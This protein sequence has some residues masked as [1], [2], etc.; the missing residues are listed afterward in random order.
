VE[1]VS[2]ARSVRE[3]WEVPRDLLLGRYPPFV[4]GGPLPRGDVPVFVLHGAEPRSLE[5]QL[6]HLD[7]NGYA[8]LTADEYLAV[9]RREQPPPE[10]AVLLTFDDGRG[11][12]WGVAAPLLERFGMRAVVFLV[13]GR[14]RSRPGPLPPTWA[15]VE[16]G[17][18]DASE[19]LDREAGEG[20]LLCWE[21]VASLS[22]RGVFD[23]QSHSLTHARIHTGGRL[24]GFATPWSRRGYDAFDQ[25]LVR[26]GDRDLLGENVP[27]GTPL[28]QSAP[29]T[30]EALRFF[31][32][33][34]VRAAC[35]ALVEAEGE[36]F[37]RRADWE[38]VLGR[39][40]P[41]APVPG[42]HETRDEQVAAIERELAESRRLLEERVGRPV[43]HLCYPWHTF[44]PTAARLSASTGYQAVFCGKVPGVPIT[45]PGGD[46]QRIA[47]LGEDYLRLLPGQGRSTLRQVL[48]EKW[49]RRFGAGGAGQ[50]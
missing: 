12:L 19:V 47:R 26:E 36:G 21:E 43:L 16:A 35:V 1:R 9:M 18:V 31:E 5:G 37:F 40:V 39:L 34:A 27:L 44:G 7:T 4:T 28:F 13:P 45:R 46:L 29:R 22:Q 38:S 3:A 42:R 17:R 11:S 2:L 6:R 50:A 32:D 41:R 33:P 24:A 10:R 15:E 25:P 20:A 23:F 30:S 8:T 48:Q 14:M 49:S